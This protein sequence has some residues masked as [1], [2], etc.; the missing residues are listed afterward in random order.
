ML[1]IATS[2]PTMAMAGIFAQ[3]NIGDQNQV[4]SV[5][6]NLADGI[7]DHPVRGISAA[8]L[9]ILRFR[10]AKEN[11]SLD[12]GFVD[13]LSNLGDFIRGV[14][15]N[16]GHTRDFFP[17]LEFFAYEKRQDKVVPVKICF[18]NEIAD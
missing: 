10:N 4:R 3:T 1:T 9:F 18:A 17:G 14:L 16:A 6:F 8:A 15:P 12:P 13:A 2:D 5:F 11:D 7:L